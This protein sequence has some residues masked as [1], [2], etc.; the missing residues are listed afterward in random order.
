MCAHTLAG[1]QGAI[2]CLASDETRLIA[3]SEGGVKLWDIH[4][5]KFKK[6]LVSGLGVQGVWQVTFNRRWLVCTLMRNGRTE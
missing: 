3:G 4:T 6:D 5:G 2:T 1:H